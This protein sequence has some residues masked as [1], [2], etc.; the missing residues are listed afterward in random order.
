[1]F[2]R[3]LALALCACL[4]CGCARATEAVPYDVIYTSANPIPDIA[5]RVRP[6]VV[7][8]VGS[9][10]TW[11]AAT[12]ISSTV[13]MGAGSGC[14]FQADSDGQGGYILTNNHVVADSELYSIEWLS[15]EVMDA[16]LVGHDDG[17][18]IAVLHFSKPAPEGAEPIPLG[19]SDALRIGEL[20]I[21]IGN[22]GSADEVLFGTVTAGIISGL[23]REDINANNFARSISVIQIDAA[24]NSGNSGGALFNLYGEVVGITN[25][26]YSSRSTSEASIDNIGF[27]IPI[28]SVRDIVESIIEKGYVSKPY[29]GVTVTD[30]TEE[31][32][33][34]GLPQ[35]AAVK[36]VVDGS[37]AQQGGLKVNDIITAVNGSEIA[38]KNAL[39]KLVRACEI[40]DK[41]KLTV[42]RQGQTLELTVVIGEQVQSMDDTATQQETPTESQ[43]FFPW[44][45]G[46]G[47]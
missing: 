28:N 41:L 2:K 20:A 30:V 35:G 12:R 14:Y 33:S 43:G 34:Y 1:M 10:E 4:L 29:I 25:A 42:Y 18:D 27:A 31:M 23:E 39:V 19:D 47:G 17:T 6:S 44:G 46:F 11:D 8:V 32:Q 40:G 7:Q 24:I 45:Y 38:D 22:P 5:D 15:G 21:C 13:E 3:I 26:K 9:C 36:G 16:T 37:P